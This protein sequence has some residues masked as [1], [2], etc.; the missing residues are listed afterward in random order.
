MAESAEYLNNLAERMVDYDDVRLYTLDYI[1]ELGIDDAELIL[2]LLVMS[3][4]WKS[5]QRNEELREDELNL[6]LGVEENE[7]FSLS[8]TDPNVTI[9]LDDDQACLS[10]DA[11][12][13]QTVNDFNDWE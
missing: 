8:D 11:V 12:L 2:S 1:G 6:L 4:L 9:T 5:R 13:D 10:L 7:D 3:F